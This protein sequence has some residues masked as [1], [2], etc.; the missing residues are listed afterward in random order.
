MGK[1]GLSG[2]GKSALLKLGRDKQ[3][4]SSFDQINGKHPLKSAIPKSYVPYKARK[5]HGG[6]VVYFNFPLAKEM[7]LIPNDHPEK[8]NKEL[9]QKLLDTFSLIIINEYD[10]INNKQFPKNEIRPN[11]YMA[12]RY[13]QLQHPNKK[14]ETS[15]DGRSIWNGQ[16]KGKGTTWDLSSCGTGG[17][18]LSPATAINKKYYESGDP[19][20]SY[21]CGYAELLDG[22][23]AAIMSEIFHNRGIK[24][25]RTLCLIEFENNFS[26]N[27]RAY[28]NLIRPSH[29]FMYLKQDDLEN[30][31]RMMDFYFKRQVENGVFPK[32]YLRLGKGKIADCARYDILEDF[33]LNRFAEAAARFENDYIFCW[34]DWDG[35]NIL[36]DGGIIDY[37]S[38][39][40]F[41][42]FHH[43]YRYDDDDRMSTNI[44][45]QKQKA[46]LTIQ[47]FLQL[48][49][50]LRTGKKAPLANFSDH[51]KLKEF[52]VKFDNFKNR[53]LLDSMGFEK[54]HINYLIE[55]KFKDVENFK[56]DFEYFERV[57][58]D[59][60]LKQVGDGVNHNPVYR[61]KDF[62]RIYPELIASSYFEFDKNIKTLSEPFDAS[63]IHE[64]LVST[65]A[66]S[67]DKQLSSY[68]KKRFWSLQRSYLKLFKCVL[69][70][71]Y[72][73]PVPL[74]N[75][76][77]SNASDNNRY[78]QITGDSMITLATELLEKKK[79]RTKSDFNT[80]ILD[81]IRLN[82]PTS[83][84]NLDDLSREQIKF[85]KVIENFREGI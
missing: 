18:K 83:E 73:T 56:N 8:L 64:L 7:G 61:M 32:K 85:L 20:I 80:S 50:Y 11:N 30:L 42:L 59:E 63:E 74:L 51:K 72:K 55:H 62:L 40:Q 66:T 79:F 14:G 68:R 33:F 19:S 24:T 78:Y 39:R 27:V 43:E 47:I 82:S 1:I 38:I 23:A 45:E 58:S 75:K 25:E 57:K 35:D 29:M 26:V 13:L 21:G 37:G 12:T 6:K 77:Q 15:G 71:F 3:T 70:K 4:Y 67:G 44:K 81:F 48:F 36:A 22:L 9:S 65:Y 69:G 49:D 17:T 76:M 28:P 60:G 52:D 34:L 10:L 41:G 16:F 84:L 54:N 2:I 5:R 31:K 46:K 53:F